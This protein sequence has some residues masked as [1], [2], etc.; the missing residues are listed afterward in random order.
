[1][2]AF[3]KHIF[4]NPVTVLLRHTSP[5]MKFEFFINSTNYF[6]KIIIVI[7]MIELAKVIYD[8]CGGWVSI[9]E[10]LTGIL[11]CGIYDALK[12]LF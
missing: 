6:M 9:K 8:F 2:E 12:K 10:I 11:I 4:F 3:C 7:K 5:R 1:M